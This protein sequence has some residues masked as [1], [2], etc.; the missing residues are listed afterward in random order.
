MQAARTPIFRYATTAIVLLTSFLSM[1]RILAHDH[2]YRAPMPLLF[3]FQYTELPRLA[4]Y[5]YPS[6][7]PKLTLKNYQKAEE[8]FELAPIQGMNLTLCYA[9]EWYRFPGSFLVP[10]EVRTEF[11]KSSFD[12]QLPKHFVERREEVQAVK[13][14]FRRKA[15]ITSQSPLG[16]NDLNTQEMDRYVSRLV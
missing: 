10:D 12:G 5:N 8:Q 14:S 1:A 7:Y 4:L 6:A 11:V 15:Q 2:Y 16:Y 13:R 9:G 3:H